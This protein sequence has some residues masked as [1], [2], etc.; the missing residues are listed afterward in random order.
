MSS[1]IKDSLRDVYFRGREEELRLLQD[2]ATGKIR[3]ELSEPVGACLACRGEQRTHLFDKAGF[4][5]YRCQACDFIYSSPQI[6]EDKLR[7]LYQSKPSYDLWMDVLISEANQQYD[8]PKY[9]RGLELIES[10]RSPGRM[11]DVGCALG[12]FLAAARDRG[13]T[14]V[15]LELNQRGY[16][17]ATTELGLEVQQKLL[18]NC[19]FEEGSFDAITL[20]GVI[21]HFKQPRE[22]L[23][24]V[25]RLLAPGGILLTFCP[26]VASLICRVVHHRAATFDGQV[27]CGYFTPETL[28]ALLRRTGFEPLSMETMQQDLT[29]LFNHLDYRPPYE[30]GPEGA[31]GFRQ[32]LGEPL[33]QQIEQF[34]EQN[35]LGYKML[36]IARRVE[37]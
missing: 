3:E 20:W 7:E 22:E 28:E 36:S 2:P 31:K 16:D 21:E 18:E 17:H 37:A 11:L 33:V 19:G 6:L 25:W 30:H 24:R 13:W 34:I 26:N 12:M 35:H 9:Q 15:G 4:E 14:P 1:F 10:H 5:Y 8:Q 32:L 27:H 23:E 29:S